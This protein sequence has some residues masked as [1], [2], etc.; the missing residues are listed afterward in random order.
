MKKRFLGSAGILA[1]LMLV[2][3][4]IISC[5]TDRRAAAPMVLGRADVVVVGA[6]S[7]G[8]MA[9]IAAREGG[10]SV[11]L[12]ERRHVTGGAA[13][14]SGDNR[15]AP[16]SALQRQYHPELND[17][18]E[19][20]MELKRLRTSMSLSRPSNPALP[21]WEAVRWLIDQSVPLIDWLMDRGLDMQIHNFARDQ[22]NRFHNAR[23]VPG[24]PAGMGHQN[25][26]HDLAV[27]R[28][29]TILLNTRGIAVQ[30][31]AGSRSRVTGVY[32]EGGGVIYA[33][34]VIL[35]T[36]GFAQDPGRFIRDWD[37]AAP[38]T[39][40]LPAPAPAGTWAGDGIAMAI[41]SGGVLWDDQWVNTLN[42]NPIVPI[43]RNTTGEGAIST[44]AGIHTIAGV[45]S[46]DFVSGM[47]LMSN[48]ERPGNENNHYSLTSDYL[49]YARQQGYR[50]FA[51]IDSSVHT[52][53]NGAT[54]YFAP[55]ATQLATNGVYQG[56][57]LQALAEAAGI[58]ANRLNHWVSI[59]NNFADGGDD[60]LMHPS[61]PHQITPTLTQ[62][63]RPRGLRTGPFFAIELVPN[64]MGTF[65]GVITEKETGRVLTSTGQFIPGLYAAGEVSNRQFWDR[66]YNTGTALL[67]SS[68]SGKLSGMHAAEFVSQR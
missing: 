44:S 57:T 49:F 31:D 15:G 12:I 50:L 66:I 17:T 33:N 40:I 68:V 62:P 23:H 11:I 63:I 8:L 61:D 19:T 51:I 45:G 35:A 13:A 59:F 64:L 24:Q 16:G 55:T 6:G 29:V 21:D 10:A 3:G 65:G 53:P 27:A 26:L 34:A 5:A 52:Y 58:P 36:G 7:A 56:A 47:Y 22:Q 42:L 37:N 38:F 54:S 67:Q 60:P 2:S 4:G 14:I 25:F 39:Y 32:T 43:S 28:G 9:A 48:G 46:F 18:A 30:Q 20:W 1:L 41:M